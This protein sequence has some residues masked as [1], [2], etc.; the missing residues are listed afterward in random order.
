MNYQRVFTKNF[1]RQKTIFN[2]F[3]TKINS[4]K[5]ISNC[6]NNHYHKQM[7]TFVLAAGFASNVT[8]QIGTFVDDSLS[9]KENS[10]ISSLVNG[11][12]LKELVNTLPTM[13]SILNLKVLSGKC[14]KNIISSS[15]LWTTSSSSIEITT[16]SL[17][18]MMT[19]RRIK[20]NKYHKFK[21]S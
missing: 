14:L 1:L 16:L 9:A 5:N 19:P 12:D 21:L 10:E 20:P 4:F 2:S 17:L 13:S 7:I 8:K 15:D 11:N 3:S 18:R 6:M